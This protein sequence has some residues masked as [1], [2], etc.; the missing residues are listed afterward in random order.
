MTADT[1]RARLATAAAALSVAAE[2]WASCQRDKGQGPARGPRYEALCRAEED[3]WRWLTAAV[4][5]LR[6]ARAAATVALAGSLGTAPPSGDLAHL[7]AQEHQT[8]KALSMKHPD[9]D[10]E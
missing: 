10:T 2:Q 3:A 1:A 9:D 8:A 5:D 7:I 6:A 4:G